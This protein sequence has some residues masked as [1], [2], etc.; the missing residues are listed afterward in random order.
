MWIIRLRR[1]LV[2]TVRN[3][4][5]EDAVRVGSSPELRLEGVTNRF[6]LCSVLA[7]QTRRLGRLIPA[8]RVAELIGVAWR[9]C[10][11]HEVQVHMDGNVPNVIREEAAAMF[12]LAELSAAP[13]AV[14]S[15]TLPKS[16]TLN[17]LSTIEQ[18]RGEQAG[19]EER[20]SPSH[21]EADIHV[22]VGTCLDSADFSYRNLS[23]FEGK[24]SMSHTKGT[25]KM[26]QLQLRAMAQ[27][28]CTLA[29]RHRERGNYIVAHALYGR[30]LEVARGIDSPEHKENGSALVS[31][32]E[33]DQQAVFEKLRS[34]EIGPQSTP[35]KGRAQKTAQ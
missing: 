20:S 27:N 7:K 26:R 19:S 18:R 21:T 34:G 24:W 30:A 5:Q 31:R 16:Q 25:D 10:T 12:A 9:N 29:N 6:L 4:L 23:G 14:G 15:S 17:G 3:R 13:V 1:W 2:P 22:S 11:E 8:M 35:Q 32:I 33:Q 28:L